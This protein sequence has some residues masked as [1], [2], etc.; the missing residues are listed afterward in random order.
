[1]GATG[2]QQNNKK[3][4]SDGRQNILLPR[5]ARDKTEGKLVSKQ[6]DRQ[7][8]FV[9]VVCF[10]SYH[11]MA[12][13]MGCCELDHHVRHCGSSGACQCPSQRYLLTYLAMV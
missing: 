1:M 8:W 3:P 10:R 2:K 11:N 5:Q 6:T 9:C 7:S 4:F 12:K 13:V